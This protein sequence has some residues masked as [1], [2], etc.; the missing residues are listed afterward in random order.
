MANLSSTEEITSGL[1]VEVS[2]GPA[3][4]K[5]AGF[6]VLPCN[7]LGRQHKTHRFQSVLATSFLILTYSGRNTSC[8]FSRSLKP[9]RNGKSFV[10]FLFFWNFVF[11]FVVV[12]QLTKNLKRQPPKR[13]PSFNLCP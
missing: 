8:G 3:I 5:V 12:L 2:A 11:F 1:R 9:N 4:H 6:C 10:L 13:L 7:K